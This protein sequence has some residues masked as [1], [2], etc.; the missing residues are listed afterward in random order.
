MSFL[1]QSMAMAV[2]LDQSLDFAPSNGDT[3][4]KMF[5]IAVGEWDAVAIVTMVPINDLRIQALL[6]LTDPPAALNPQSGMS[7]W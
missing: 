5:V 4:C 1:Q 2:S 7:S 6:T 3:P